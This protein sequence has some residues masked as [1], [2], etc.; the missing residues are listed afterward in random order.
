MVNC[1]SVNRFDKTWSQR[2]KDWGGEK[3]VNPRQLFVVVVVLTIGTFWMRGTRERGGTA[4]QSYY[5]CW[6]IEASMEVAGNRLRVER[7][8]TQLTVGVASALCVTIDVIN[9]RWSAGFHLNWWIWMNFG[10]SGWSSMFCVKHRFSSMIS[11]TDDVALF[12]DVFTWFHRWF[13]PFGT[14]WAALGENA[15]WSCVL[16]RAERDTDG[17]VRWCERM[18]KIGGGRR[19]TKGRSGTVE[20]RQGCT[21]KQIKYPRI[22]PDAENWALHEV[23]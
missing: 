18:K 20:G 17:I 3:W 9:Y 7:G 5:G 11:F 1:V 8:R 19:P 2:A 22:V 12:I 15:F 21:D 10:T 6:S 13:F 4:R 23:S 16:D 14:R